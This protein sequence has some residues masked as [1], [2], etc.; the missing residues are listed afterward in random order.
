MMPFPVPG[1]CVAGLL[2]RAGCHPVEAERAD[3]SDSRPSGAELLDGAAF[4]T[5][6]M[7]VMA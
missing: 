5:D 3:K 6:S 1:W 4:P 2:P 7:K